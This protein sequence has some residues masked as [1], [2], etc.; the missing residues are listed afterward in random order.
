VIW[1]YKASQ[2]VHSTAVLDAGR[3]AVYVG[4]K[5][6]HLHAVDMA[7]GKKIWRTRLYGVVD[8]SPALTADG[9]IIVG[10][11]DR[12]VYKV[13]QDTGAVR[14]KFKTKGHVYSS[15]YIGPDKTIYIGS[16][17]HTFYALEEKFFAKKEIRHDEF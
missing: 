4:S 9:G 2:E 13:D 12:H 16:G 7:T 8:S 11:F 14:W 10:S 3:G 15:P 5:D 17:D 6:Q 1:D